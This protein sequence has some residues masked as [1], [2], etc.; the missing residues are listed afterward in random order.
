MTAIITI[1][2][3][4]III[5]I[6]TIET[7]SITMTDQIE[8]LIIVMET[9][10]TVMTTP[11][12]KM[13]MGIIVITTTTG[14]TTIEMITMVTAIPTV[15][16]VRITRITAYPTITIYAVI[17]TIRVITMKP[18]DSKKIMMIIVSVVIVPINPEMKFIIC[19][20]TLQQTKK[21]FAQKLL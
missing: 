21:I 17:A 14:T 13:I 6:G 2:I 3:R 11:E 7:K 9:T 20:P 5:I 4:K 1:G 12:T 15:V 19:T 8:M 18:I 10:A 16:L